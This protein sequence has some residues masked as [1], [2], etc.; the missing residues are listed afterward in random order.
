MF[1]DVFRRFDLAP[2]DRTSPF[3]RFSWPSID[4]DQDERTV[5]VT[6]ELPGL[7]EKDVKVEMADGV[8]SVSGEKKSETKDDTRLFNERF[9][10]R[11]ERRIPLEG[12]NEDGIDASF[13]NGVLT[14]TLPKSDKPR[15]NV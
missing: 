2:F 11:F 7:E 8:L 1:N 9:Y 14:V 5:R 15:E 3:D 13:K 10:G 6:A 4:V 12:I